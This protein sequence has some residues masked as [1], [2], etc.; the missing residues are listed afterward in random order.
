MT[1]RKKKN[2]SKSK[3]K[4]EGT[5]TEFKMLK[6]V[7]RDGNFIGKKKRFRGRKYT[8]L[9]SFSKK[10]ERSRI[11][12]KLG[13]LGLNLRS[14]TGRNNGK[15]VFRLWEKKKMFSESTKLDQNMT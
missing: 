7:G 6:K 2:K 10:E 9:K 1:K 13:K 15:Q 3:P 8:Y 4:Q 14:S 11:K 12:S 5:F